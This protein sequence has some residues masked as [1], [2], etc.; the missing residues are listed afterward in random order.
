MFRKIRDNLWDLGLDEEFLEL[1]LK[2]QLVKKK[3]IFDKLGLSILKNIFVMLKAL[4]KGKD[5]LHTVTIK[6]Q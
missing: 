1:A 2:A 4:I 3:K 5:K 6:E